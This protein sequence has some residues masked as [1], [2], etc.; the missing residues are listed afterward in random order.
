[1]NTY[2]I[3]SIHY[4]IINQVRSPSRYSH[5]VFAKKKKKSLKSYSR[6]VQSI[7]EFTLDDITRIRNIY[8]AKETADGV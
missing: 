4:F 6:N 2:F 3:S 5:G 1:M 8:V 7:E